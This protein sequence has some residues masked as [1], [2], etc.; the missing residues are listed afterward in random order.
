M[1]YTSHEQLA[2]QVRSAGKPTRIVGVIAAQDLHALEAVIAAAK[3][4]IVTPV[5]FGDKNAIHASLKSLGEKPDAFEIVQADTPEEA[6]RLAGIAAYE[7]RV[8]FLM[9]GGIP[10][11]KMLRALFNEDTH[12]RTGHLI[13]HM[14]LVQAPGYH[15][16]FAITDT[17]ITVYPTLEQKAQ[18]IRNSVGI[19]LKM[20]FD[21]PKVAAL[22]AS[23][24]VSPKIIETVEANELKLMNQR[25]EIADCV[26]DGPL[27]LDLAMSPESAKIKKCASEVA[28]NAD[29]LLAPNI[30]AGN[31]LI[32]SL[33]V[34]GQGRIAGLVIG[35][36]VPITLS[37]RAAAAEDKFLPLVLAASATH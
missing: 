25:G 12:F 24:D 4:K 6:S 11:A 21:T 8:H 10:T 2:E 13:S 5:L 30:A 32:K 27:S 34:F 29:L 17:S 16:L 20:G 37:S 15:K 7:K 19:L 33:R 22:A 9:K 23:E 36:R 18:L 35:G 1:I 31:I 26:I 3:Q 28:G 14:A